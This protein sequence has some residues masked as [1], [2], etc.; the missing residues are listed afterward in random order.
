[1]TSGGGTPAGGGTPLALIGAS[2]APLILS[3]SR[4]IYRRVETVSF[5]DDAWVR[6]HVSVDFELRLRDV[7]PRPYRK[8]PRPV[9]LAPLALLAKRPLRH[10]DVRDEA[11]AALPVLTSDQNT[12]VAAGMLVSQAQAFLRRRYGRRLEREIAADLREIA[13]ADGE[14]HDALKAKL[15]R[16][17]GAAR[18]NRELLGRNPRLRALVGALAENFILL[19]PIAD[20]HRRVIKYAYDEPL[21]TSQLPLA[22]RV[23]EAFGWRAAGISWSA[24]SVGLARSYHLE[25]EAPQDLEIVSAALVTTDARDHAKVELTGPSGRRAHLLIGGLSQDAIGTGSV[26]L[27]ARRAGLLRAAV[28]LAV[29]TAALLTLGALRIHELLS[30]DPASPVALL[31]LVPALL[32]AY[33][34]RPGEHE[35]ASSLLV[36]V[37]CLILLI[38]VLAIAAAVAIIGG[39]GDDHARA[40]LFGCT[41]AA[42]LVAIGLSGSYLL[43]RLPADDMEK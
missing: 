13:G 1:M 28:V 29:L 6:R 16:R 33:L 35:L 32:A 3:P 23:T 7:E 21:P 40:L 11:G 34:G 39:L 18:I 4:W 8:Q 37:R 31:A 5:I 36:G 22:L 30:E 20:L 10:F 19:V 14:G 17:E 27:R 2:L 12:L 24:P 42:W 26:R 15:F 38:G 43:P 41:G 25:I 9:Y